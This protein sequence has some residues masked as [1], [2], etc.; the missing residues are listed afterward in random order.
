MR[1]ARWEVIVLND[2]NYFLLDE[3]GEIL[4]MAN[5][6]IEAGCFLCGK[7]KIRNRKTVMGKFGY[8]VTFY[9]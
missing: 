5:K 1:Q 8:V 3:K 9:I 6:Q 7:T 2:N 4:H